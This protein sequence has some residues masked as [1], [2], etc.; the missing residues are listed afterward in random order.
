MNKEPEAERSGSLPKGLLGEAREGK[1]ITL[2]QKLFVESHPSTAAEAAK[3]KW[4]EDPR[5]GGWTQV[6]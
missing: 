2:E 3:C 4:M 5:G 6:C 1:P